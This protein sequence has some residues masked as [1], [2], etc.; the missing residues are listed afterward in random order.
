MREITLCNA[1]FL[2]SVSDIA[3]NMTH[4]D[5]KHQKPDVMVVLHLMQNS[6]HS[7]RNSDAYNTY[8]KLRQ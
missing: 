4:A 5:L 6:Y 7:N 3:P 2:Y 8:H 1:L